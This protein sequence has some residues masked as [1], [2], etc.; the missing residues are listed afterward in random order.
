M[1]KEIFWKIFLIV[2]MLVC[3]IVSA[4][5]TYNWITLKATTATD[6][7]WLGWSIL[8]F[9]LLVKVYVSDSDKQKK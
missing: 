3:V 7:F 6:V 4:G 9:V 5:I 2:W 8:T 1:S